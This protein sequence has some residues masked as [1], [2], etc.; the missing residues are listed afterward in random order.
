MAT[1]T[2]QTPPKPTRSTAGTRTATG[3]KIIDP[4]RIL[5]Q[6]VWVII[7]SAVV[8]IFV[9]LVAFV[10][11]LFFFPSYDGKVV[12]EL[13]PDLQTAD[14]VVSA[15]HRTADT[16]TRLART[17]T[18]R[19][20]SE[21]VLTKALEDRDVKRTIWAQQFM[22]G[23]GAF[24]LNEALLELQEELSA[25]HVRDT[26]TFEIYWYGS[27]ASDVPVILTAVQDSYMSALSDITDARYNSNLKTFTDQRDDLDNLVS[28]LETEKQNFVRENNITSLNEAVNER[29]GRIEELI[30]QISETRS[31]VEVMGS[32]TQQ[33]QAKITGRLD[34]S[35]DDVRFAEQDPIVMNISARI[36]DLRI[37]L[38]TAREKFHDGHLSVRQV[39]R[40]LKASEDEKD[41]AIKEIVHRDL[42]AEFKEVSDQRDSFERLLSALE[43][44]FDETQTS[45]RDYASALGE[46]H[47]LDRRLEAAMEDRDE[48]TR[49]IADINKVRVRSDASKVR[50]F[51]GATMPKELHFP[52]IEYVVPA[53]LVIVV[54]LT[55][56]IIFVR[57]LLDNRIKYPNEIVS[58][59][60]ARLLGVVPDV[61]DDPTGVESV[62]LVVRNEPDSVMAE[63]FRQTAAHVYKEM[64]GGEHQSLLLISGMPDAGTTT[65]S[66]NL[67]G[68][69][70]AT[71]RKV[72]IVDANFRRP[73]LEEACGVERASRGL[74]DALAGEA[75]VESIVI[76]TPDSI[77]IIGAGS[78][79]N[80]VFERL[81]T[82]A[83]DDLLATLKRRYDIVL[84]DGPPGVVS[85]DA[86]VLASK[87][88]AT[89]LVIRAG[90]EER[91]LIGR[92]INQLR[93]MQAS[94]IGVIFNRPRHTAGGYF[95]KNFKTMASYSPKP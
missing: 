95:K 27:V 40:L 3:G 11:S 62:D 85:G 79:I 16:V 31:S 65:I 74:G 89:A 26:N 33:L 92:L 39:E 23:G 81:N 64:V 7:G 93:Q 13:S 83:M 73:R 38:G 59:A 77:D 78:E 53:G 68:S 88:D 47:A 8:G 2:K 70:V 6:N 51:Q 10:V 75:P 35:N 72:V 41:L 52:K 87:C 54:G 91:G 36:R 71:G 82:S 61:A 43:Q 25:Y 15:D 24:N 84:I 4:V 44:D 57:E 50:L 28:M 32:R 80:R 9:G 1:M 42:T 37:E 46:L 69:L 63:T 58:I 19:V 76:G 14:A 12:F 90:S 45:L 18:S 22:E 30:A 67:A 17:E 60:G 5:R 20:F 86:L 56:G 21:K 29:R 94:F 49:T 66:T 55:L 48:I 34:P